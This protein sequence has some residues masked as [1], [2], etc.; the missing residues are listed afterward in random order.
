MTF[1]KKRLLNTIVHN[2]IVKFSVVIP[3]HTIVLFSL[4][5]ELR[6]DATVI[7]LAVIVV[8][9]LV[10]TI[11]NYVEELW[12]FFR[13]HP[14]GPNR[15]Y[16]IFILTLFPVPPFSLEILLFYISVCPVELFVDQ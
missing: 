7:A 3:L 2:N 13:V 1:T 4:I 15:N 16:V 14:H 8:L 12:F 10:L 5:P 9:L 11:A 6:G